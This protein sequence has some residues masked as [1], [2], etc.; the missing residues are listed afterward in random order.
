MQPQNESSR[1][2]ASRP[3]YSGFENAATSGRRTTMRYLARVS[4]RLGHLLMKNGDVRTEHLVQA[5][6]TQ[7]KAGGL[8]G[9]ILLQMGACSL[10]S[11]TRALLHQ[12]PVVSPTAKVANAEN[13]G[14][15]LTLATNPRRTVMT[16]VTSDVLCLLLAGICG[17]GLRM[18]FGIDGNVSIYLPLLPALALYILSFA[19]WHLYP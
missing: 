9:T 4:K 15:N 2:S 12:S 5:L 7:Q 11:V 17:L 18:L 14:I 3:L 19:L 8:L 6:K 10:Q 13:A 16:L 1:Q